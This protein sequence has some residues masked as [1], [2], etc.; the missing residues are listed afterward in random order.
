MANSQAEGVRIVEIR[1][2]EQPQIE[3]AAGE[4]DTAISAMRDNRGCAGDVFLRY[5]VT[6]QEEIREQFRTV[7]KDV[8]SYI[9]NAEYRFF[10]NQAA[11]VLV[12]ARILQELKIA[13]FD[14]DALF[15]YAMRLMGTLSKTIE[16]EHVVTHEDAFSMMVNDLTPR[17]LQTAEYRD[18]RDARGPEPV[19][20]RNH[21][22]IAGRF[23]TGVASKEPKAGML[24]LSKKD[25][26][27]WCVKQRIDMGSLMSYAKGH[28]F[29]VSD[30]ERFNVTRGTELPAVQVV[31]ASF[32]MNRAQGLVSTPRLTVHNS[33]S[34]VASSQQQAV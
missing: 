15:K 28:G 2:D 5:V 23:I 30:G 13:S 33:G 31:C 7:L 26:K 6:H 21:L 32:D 18:G 29:L 27:D 10:R 4:V 17:I 19:A 14:F 12:S 9:P 1:A 24:Y 3:F 25:I 22:T 34:I 20:R 16:E 11:S 8:M